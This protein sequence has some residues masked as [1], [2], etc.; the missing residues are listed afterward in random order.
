MAQFSAA[1]AALNTESK[2]NLA[3]SKGIHKSTY[4][5]YTYEDAMNLLAKLPTIA[6]IIY[7]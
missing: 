5:E 3:Y 1:I 7:K 2:F 4:W 6:S